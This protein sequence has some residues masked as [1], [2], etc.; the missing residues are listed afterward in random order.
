MLKSRLPVSMLNK[1]EVILVI[2]ENPS[3]KVLSKPLKRE[4]LPL[5]YILLDDLFTNNHPHFDTFIN[6]P[7]QLETLIIRVRNRVTFQLREHKEIGFYVINNI[8]ITD[9]ETQNKPHP[10]DKPIDVFFDTLRQEL[11]LREIDKLC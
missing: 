9:Q 8:L 11:I 10:A 5:L 3:F 2:T 6:N 1:K 4:V 7:G